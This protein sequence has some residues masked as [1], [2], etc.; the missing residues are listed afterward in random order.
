MSNLWVGGHSRSS[1]APLC[2]ATGAAAVEEA[3]TAGTLIVGDLTYPPRHST[4]TAGSAS[5]QSGGGTRL[6]GSD[7]RE[8]GPPEQ[9]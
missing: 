7:Q 1:G 3:S 8:I 2:K 6:S 9:P 4:H 5:D